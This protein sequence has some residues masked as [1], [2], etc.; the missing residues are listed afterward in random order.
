MAQVLAD[1]KEW[2]K[3]SEHSHDTVEHRTLVN[4]DGPGRMAVYGVRNGAAISDV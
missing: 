4:S 1:G 3:K 2:S